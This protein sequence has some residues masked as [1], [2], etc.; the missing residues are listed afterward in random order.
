MTVTAGPGERAQLSIDVER[1]DDT[2]IVCLAGELDL[3]ATDELPAALRAA[4]RADEVVLDLER[5]EFV[6]SAGLRVL[7]DLWQASQD[8]GFGLAIVGARGHVLQGAEPDRAGRRP[9]DRSPSTASRR[10]GGPTA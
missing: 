8:D 5:L 3:A 1:V 9:A 7:Y 2:L 10:D 4:G 6:D